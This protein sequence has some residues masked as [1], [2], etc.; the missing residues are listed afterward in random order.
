MYMQGDFDLSLKKFKF[1]LNNNINNDLADN[2]QFW[3][4][5][6]L[7]SEKKYQEAINEFNKVLN[8]NDSNK[9]SEA[10]YKMGL[11]YLKMNDNIKAKKMF[12]DIIRNYPKSKYFNKASEF[13]LNIK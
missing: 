11:C 8:Y 10:I 6:I 12:N 9:K 5:Q 2:C 3:I 7:F 13:L 4:G 1:L